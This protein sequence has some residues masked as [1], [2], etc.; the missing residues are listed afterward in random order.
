MV[1]LVFQSNQQ[2]EYVEWLAH[3]LVGNFSE[4]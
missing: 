3:A 2:P 1:A 4:I